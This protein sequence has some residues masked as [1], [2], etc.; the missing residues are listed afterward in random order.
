M[1]TSHWASHEADSDSEADLYVDDVILAARAAWAAQKE[2]SDKKASDSKAPEDDVL[3][4]KTCLTCGGLISLVIMGSVF[5]PLG[6]L[7]S[8][9]YW[10]GEFVGATERDKK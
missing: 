4:L 9:L 8:F 10:F 5:W 2:D 1:S 7:L 3:D 6:L